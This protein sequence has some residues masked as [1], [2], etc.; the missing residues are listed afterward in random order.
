VNSNEKLKDEIKPGVIF[1]LKQINHFTAPEGKNALY[2]YYLVYVKEDGEV[3]L[4]HAHVKKIL[5]LY[6]SLC[7]GKQEP[8]RML[9]ELFYKE[10]R[11]G[12]QMEPYKELLE[13]AG[14]EIAGKI[15]QQ[16]TLNIF[17]LGSLD[18]LVSSSNTNLQ[19][20]EVVSYLIV[21]E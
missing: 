16:S 12:R 9:Y 18:S 1:C 14:G 8:E 7:L 3:L 5:D 2:P 11:N 13:Q 20:F 10:T 4:S 6:R 15:D 21:K 19:D 17:S